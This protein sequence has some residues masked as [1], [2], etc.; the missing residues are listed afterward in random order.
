MA[1][2]AKRPVHAPAVKRRVHWQGNGAV[3]S[4]IGVFRHWA[5]P[6]KPPVL[7][8]ESLIPQGNWKYSIKNRV[9]GL[10]LAAGPIPSWAAV[11]KALPG[12]PRRGSM[13]MRQSRFDFI[14]HRQTS[15][16]IDCMSSRNFKRQGELRGSGVSVA[17]N[18]RRQPHDKNRAPLPT[19]ET[20]VDG[21]ASRCT[22]RRTMPKP[23]PGAPCAPLYDCRA[24]T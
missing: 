9:N 23:K 8:P 11:G 20:Q 2:F 1:L 10:L 16:V 12:D 14:V 7:G 6:C 5:S 13:P 21:A 19:S 4:M 15:R 17:V 18:F 3:T 24:I 22:R